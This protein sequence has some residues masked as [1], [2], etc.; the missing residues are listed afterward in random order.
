[1]LGDL[2][3]MECETAFGFWWVCEFYF[4]AFRIS[5]R[6]LRTAAKFRSSQ[7]QT[8]TVTG[9]TP[10]RCFRGNAA[11]AIKVDESEERTLH[12]ASPLSPDTNQKI[13]SLVQRLLLERSIV[14]NVTCEDSL[15]EAGLNSMDMLNLV[16]TVEAEFDVTIPESAITLKNLKTV[17]TIGSLVGML[18]SKAITDFS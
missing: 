9:N 12:D 17:S 11:M 13:L 4:E 14:R 3:V 10:Y 7:P 8:V 6:F 2:A 18:Q 16:L 1:V 15:L 5:A